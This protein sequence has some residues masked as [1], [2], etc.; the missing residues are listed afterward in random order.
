LILHSLLWVPHQTIDSRFGRGTFCAFHFTRATSAGLNAAS[1]VVPVDA[2]ILWQHADRV[3]RCGD[4]PRVD[5]FFS[6]SCALVVSLPSTAAA[7]SVLTS[8][9][10]V[11]AVD[12]NSVRTSAPVRATSF[13]LMFTSFSFEVVLLDP[14]VGATDAVRGRLTTGEQWV[15]KYVF[16][17]FHL[18][19]LS[20]WPAANAFRSSLPNFI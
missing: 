10:T 5:K 9:L 11:S 16:R 18:L 8:T 13:E 3:I 17:L 2:R 15:R 19:N 7:A 14:S 6:A 4:L 1:A 12:P 20:L